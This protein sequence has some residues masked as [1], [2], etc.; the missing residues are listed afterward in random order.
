MYAYP[1]FRRQSASS[2][3]LL[4]APSEEARALSNTGSGRAKPKEEVL[5]EAAN[6]VAGHG[7]DPADRLLVLAHC[8]LQFG[9]FQGQ[10]FR[11]LLENSLGYAV[12]LLHSISKE[13]VQA[14][15]L[16]ENKQLF[17][18]FTSQIAEMTVELE[19]F[20]RKQEMQKQAKDTG[21][22]G[23]LMVEFGDFKGRSMKEV[24]EDQSQKAQALINY[25]KTADA[26]PNTNMAIFKT[27]VLKRRA[28]ATTLP[29]SAST[30]TGRPPASST[31][32][33]PSPA[34]STSSAPPAGFQSGAWKPATVK[35]LL[36]RGNLSPSQL[37]KKLMSPVKLSPAPQLTSP[38]PSKP[39]QLFPSD[40]AEI[41]DEEMVSAAAQC[42]AQLN[43]ATV[44]REACADP[45]PAALLHQP[46]AELPSHW[47]DQLPPYQ[48][49][50]IRHTLFKANPRTGKPELVS[51]LKLWWYP[52]QPA[53]I[54]TQPPA[55][56]DHFFCRPLFLWMPQKMWL[57]PLVC[58]RPACGKHRLTAA[59]VYRTVRKVLD[60]DG[61][62]DLATEY[63]ECKRCSK[64]YPA[65]SE[66]I[67]GQLDVGHRSKF[68]ALLTY[69][70][71]CGIRVLRMMRERTMGNSVTQLYKK[72]QEQH[73]E[74]WME[75]VLQYLTACEPFTRSAVVRPSVF[76]EP[77]C[78]PALPKPKWLLAVYARDVLSR[79]H[80]VKAKITS[81]FGSVLKMD[82]T[83][84]VTK[85]LAGAAAGTAAW[86]TN[87]GNEY[88]QVLVSVLTA[89]EGQALDT[90]AAGLVKRYRE[91]GEAPP[92]VIYVDRD[93]CS[94]HGPCRVKAMFA[95]WDELQ[96][97]LDIW[98]FMRR[99]AAGVTTEAHPLY[100]IFMARLST[101]IFEWDPEDVAALRRAKEGELAARSVGNI[102]E[103]AV[104]TRIT[105]RELALHCRRRTRG[106]E[107]TNRL[108]GSLISL[109]DSASGKDTLGVPLLDHERIQQIWMEQQ[110]HLGCI[111]D[112]EDFQLYIKTGT[113]KKGNVEL[114]CY[115]CARGSTSL[116][117]FHLHL[118]RFIPGTSASDAHFQ[119]YLLEGLMRW[120]DDRM[121]D[122]VKGAP[123][124]R[125]YSSALREAVDQL[126]QKVL[127]RCWDERYRT[128]GAYTGELLGMEYLYSQTGKE[129]TPVLQNPEEEDRLVEEVND[130]DFQDEGFVEESMEDITVPVLYEDD[131]SR[132]LQSR[133]SSLTSPQASPPPP[134]SPP[135]PSSPP[136]SSHLPS[137]PPPSPPPQAPASPADVPSSS[138]SDEAQGAVIGP[139]GIAGW[140]K[141]QD[142]AVYLVDLREAS[143]FTDLQ[144]TQI[145]QLW[146]AL[147]EVDKQRV[148]YQ[149]RH[150][151]RLTSGRFKAPKRSGVTPG[152][153]SV[154]RCLIG[155]PGGPAQWPSTSRLVEAI[156]TKLCSLHKSP[157]KKSGVSTPRWS[158][159]LDSYHHIREL[160]LNTPRLMA[161]TTLQLFEL[162]Q[163]TLIQWFQRR[164]KT[165]EMSVLSQ[166]MAPTNKIP[167]APN[168][169]LAPKE[170][171]EL[172]P[173]TSG[174]RHQ[175]VLPPNLEGQAPVLR[176]RQT[177]RCCHPHSTR[178]CTQPHRTSA[179]P[180][181]LGSTLGAP[182]SRFTERNRR[183][184][185]LEEESGVPKRRYLRGVAYNTCGTCGQP[186][187]KEFGHSRYGSATFCP[188]ASQGKSLE[189]WLKEQRAQK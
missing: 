162:N 103:E 120:N 135:Q 170:T 188:Q 14:N 145:V 94:Q 158:K 25:L 113:L 108:I 106:V 19:K 136:P 30:S 69:R 55:S 61:W 50:W 23:Y 175:F 26:R 78:L 182:V 128:P 134:P 56:P 82:S 53:L 80:E 137:P 172:L 154:K 58:V 101:C 130:E 87:V 40:S 35:S 171:L 97:R 45:P 28:A 147:P 152:V 68:P 173:P 47:K 52:P 31:S 86:C 3:R 42:E 111:Q 115:R 84:K 29:S 100:G 139:D 54:H 46:S 62:Y 183:R 66:D 178:H 34:P 146:T 153:E 155:H 43:T 157:T 126:S 44:P 105:R 160:V 149:P 10:R 91:A 7:G 41:D 88:G 36:A 122:A 60:I 143:Y 81:I 102:S 48:H 11:W 73:S 185:A 159:I 96:V 27:Y 71:S 93:C 9:M 168:Q 132:A 38:R 18:E 186:K 163:K 70:Y 49:E 65:W 166:G 124:I 22:Q 8:Q 85:K 76:A 133:P 116:E 164:Q 165:Q 33:A 5:A 189:E 177:T 12:Y 1:V 141:V 179:G 117:S 59:G 16:S 114:C 24:Y 20:S 118:N 32:S 176:A 127:G 187:T 51:P 161:E 74:A 4:M 129:L 13:T 151:V 110:K 142:L 39:R 17:Q 150:Q 121:E 79:L 180:A 156:C 63:L 119:A 104:T 140:D 90:M 131:P 64:K 167:V 57:F 144:V 148:N 112:P 92:K 107:E 169:L 174:P 83:K 72:L 95:G 125:S 2:T 6:F 15:P 77:P 181:Q 138:M 67:L 89:G 123:S 21:D 37:V 98:H 75:R 109:F 99:F 184:R